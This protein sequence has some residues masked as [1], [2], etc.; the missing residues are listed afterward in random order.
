[1]RSGIAMSQESVLD[2]PAHCVLAS[3][4]QLRW[5]M[6]TIHWMLVPLGFVALAGMGVLLL[7]L[8][9]IL[10]PF[11]VG[12]LLVAAS[13][14]RAVRDEGRSARQP[15]VVEE[16]ASLPA[17]SMPAGALFSVCDLRD[18][19]ACSHDTQAPA[20]DP[21]CSQLAARYGSAGSGLA[22]HAAL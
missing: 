12:L 20:V 4:L 7:P 21:L 11:G 1:M 6:K 10:I 2:Q 13:A 19:E 18:C 3:P 22:P 14:G 15:I 16:A 9:P 8:L 17:R 5:P